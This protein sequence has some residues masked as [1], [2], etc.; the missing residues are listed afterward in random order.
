MGL[1]S[2]VAETWCNNYNRKEGEEIAAPNRQ[3]R[4]ISRMILKILEQR[5]ASRE[6]KH[7]GNQNLREKNAIQGKPNQKVQVQ[8]EPGKE[9]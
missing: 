8:T 9:S 3:S 4:E 6:Q 5:T 2:H 7:A 1:K